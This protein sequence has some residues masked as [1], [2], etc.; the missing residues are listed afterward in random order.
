MSWYRES[1]RCVARVYND[2][3]SIN[4]G[5]S[6]DPFSVTNIFVNYTVK[7][8]SFLR[9]SN[10]G[11]SVNNLL[12]NHNVVSITPGTTTPVVFVPSGGD[13]LTLMPGRSVMASLTFGY[14][15]KR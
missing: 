8:A 7:N 9:G 3:G 4:Q 2:Y 13:F 1:S 12:D 11:L 15:P 10:V 5:I 6:I 14:A